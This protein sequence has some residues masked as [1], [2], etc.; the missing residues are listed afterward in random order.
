MK[1]LLALLLCLMIVLL[2]IPAAIAEAEPTVITVWLFNGD[3][4]QLYEAA[5]VEWNELHPDQ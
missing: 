4:E 5:E 3:H 1:K 2:A